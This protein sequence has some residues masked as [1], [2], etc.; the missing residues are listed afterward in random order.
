[1]LMYAGNIEDA[2]LVPLDLLIHW[3]CY[4]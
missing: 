3:N 2:P 1:M 4:Q